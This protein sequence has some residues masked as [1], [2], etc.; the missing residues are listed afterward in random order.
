MPWVKSKAFPHP[1][2][3]DRGWGSK[4]W[5]KMSFDMIDSSTWLGLGDVVN[6]FRKEDLKLNPIPL[7]DGGNLQYIRDIPHIFCYRSAP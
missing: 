2:F 4:H 3:S 5:N 6:D 7:M 1:M